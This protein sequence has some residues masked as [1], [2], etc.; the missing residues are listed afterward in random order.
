MRRRRHEPE[1][2]DVLVTRLTLLLVI[3]TLFG[4]WLL[5]KALT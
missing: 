3:L 5:W 4:G 2:E 1:L